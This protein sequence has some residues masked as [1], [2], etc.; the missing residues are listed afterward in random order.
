MSLVGKL[1]FACFTQ[2]VNL[3]PISHVPQLAIGDFA[4][5]A[6]SVLSKRHGEAA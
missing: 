1:G 5:H 4:A 2:L 3:A 6:G